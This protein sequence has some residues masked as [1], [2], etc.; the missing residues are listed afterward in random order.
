[1]TS[2]RN[3]RGNTRTKYGNIHV[4]L[5]DGWTVSSKLEN[6][7]YN[8]LVLMKKARQIKYF[9]RQVPFYLPNK[10]K[11][12]CDFQVF[13]NDGT[14][15]YEDVKGFLTAACKAKIALVEQCYPIKIKLVKFRTNPQ[16]EDEYGNRNT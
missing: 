6:A 15:V 5:E 9:L 1:M 16:Y 12:I 7:R 2:F 8:E 14:V 3:F 10:N 13:H 11:Y 4:E